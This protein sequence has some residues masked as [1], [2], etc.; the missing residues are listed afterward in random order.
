[1]VKKL[2][3]LIF[4][5]FGSV[6]ILFGCG[7]PYKDLK[8]DVSTSNIV[9][10]LNEP[11]SDESEDVPEIGDTETGSDTETDVPEDNPADTVSYPSEASFVIKVSGTGKNVSGEINIEQYAINGV[12]D[13]VS[14]EPITTDTTSRD[15]AR[16]KVTAVR[17]GSGTIVVQT[18]EGSKRHEI[19]V[20]VY[21]PIKG[22]SFIDGPK[23][24][25]YGSTVD[26]NQFLTFEPTDT[27]QKEMKFYIEDNFS[28]G[29]ISDETGIIET[30]YAKIENGILTSKIS[31][32]Y[33]VN[34]S[35]QK[36]VRIY[37]ISQFNPNV[38][39]E[40]IDLPVLNIVEES[41]ITLTAQME[42]NNLTLSKLSSGY[43]EI[44]LGHNIPDNKFVYSRDVTLQITDEY[45]TDQ[46]YVISTN[47][48]S[49]TTSNSI[50]EMD[51]SDEQARYNY[52]GPKENYPYKKFSF[53]QLK[54]GNDV[55]EVYIDRR[56]Y[57]GLFTI[58][59]QI[60]VTVKDF[61]TSLSATDEN[62]G[63]AITNG[64]VVYNAYGGNSL[65]TGVVVALSP[66]VNNAYKVRVTL[67][68]VPEINGVSGITMQLVNASEITNNSLVDSGT[69]IYLKHNFDYDQLMEIMQSETKPQLQIS[70]TFNLAPVTGMQGYDDYIITETIELNLKAG[71]TDIRIPA[72]NQEIKINAVTG[73]A[74]NQMQT[75]EQSLQNAVMTDDDTT[76][77]DGEDGGDG[78]DGEE[79]VT[80]IILATIDNQPANLQEL[81]SSIKILTVNGNSSNMDAMNNQ[82]FNIV[83]KEGPL[84]GQYNR[85]VLEPKLQADQ[86]RI[87]V[88]IKTN[89]N[90]TKTVV[91]DVFVPIVF[92]TADPDQFDVEIYNQ[93][94][95]G[96]YIYDV[97]YGSYK[98]VLRDTLSII[99]G[100]YEFPE[101]ELPLVLDTYK[102][103]TVNTLTLSVD[104]RVGLNFYNYVVLNNDLGEPKITRVNYNS[105]VTLTQNREYYT[106]EYETINGV[107]VPFIVTKKLKTNQPQIVEVRVVG[108][109]NEGNEVTL[110]KQINLNI[111]EPVTSIT[112]NPISSSLY[113]ADSLG[114][115][116]LDGSKLKFNVSVRPANA[117][118]NSNDVTYSFRNDV[119]YSLVGNTRTFEIRVEHLISLD[120]KTGEA[121]AELNQEAIR[122]L[123]EEYSIDSGVAIPYDQV[124]NSIF[125]NNVIVT[126]YATLQQYEKPAITASSTI[127][128]QNATKVEKIIPSTSS[129]GVYFD[130]RK[131]QDSNYAGETITFNV[132][133]T[134]AYNKT[135]I[136]N[137]GDE[138]VVK[139]VSGVDSNNRLIGNSITIKPNLNAGR[140]YIR[141]ASEDSY[142][143]NA[144]TGIAT[145]TSYLDISV[146]VADGTKQYPFEIKNANEFL[147]IANDFVKNSSGVYTNSYYYV[148]T[149]TFSIANL[150]FG[151]FNGVFNG[152]LS[153][154]F[155][156]D[157][158][159][160][161]YSQQN[162]ING[163]TMHVDVTPTVSSG[164][165]NV[166][167]YGIFKEL[168]TSAEIEN[169][170]LNDVNLN[171]NITKNDA[172]TDEINIGTIAGVNYGLISNSSV[173]G[174]INITTNA[175]NIN[176]GGVVGVNLSHFS[177]NATHTNGTDSQGNPAYVI[178]NFD[179]TLTGVITASTNQNSNFVSSQ[180]NSSVNI[181][182]VGNS[183]ENSNNINLGGVAGKVETYATHTINGKS[184]GVGANFNSDTVYSK[185]VSV[186][187]I[188]T[189]KTISNLTVASSIE[190]VDETGAPKLANIGGVAGYSDS[191]IFDNINVL[192]SLHGH[193]NIGGIVGYANHS[194][195]TNSSVEFANQGQVGAQTISISGY[196]N[197]G[198][199]VG[200]AKNINIYYSY[201]RAYFNNRA[202]DNTDYFG[203][204]ALLDS[205]VQEKNVGGLV[206]FIDG[207]EM[208][209][210]LST[211]GES[212]G[213][214]VTK[215]AIVYDEAVGSYVE[216]S[217]IQNY[218]VENLINSN[219]VN[220]IFNSYFNA[221]INVSFNDISK[222]IYVGG[223]V[224]STTNTKT[225][226]V[227]GDASAQKGPLTI[228]NSYVYG[229][230][231]QQEVLSQTI[232]N[233]VEII[234]SKTQ[235][236]G[237]FTTYQIGTMGVLEKLEYYNYNEDFDDLIKGGNHLVEIITETTTQTVSEEEIRGDETVKVEYQIQHITFN[238]IPI[239]QK[240]LGNQEFSISS[241]VESNVKEVVE[242]RDN[243][244]VKEITKTNTYSLNAN[245][246]NI[247]TVVQNSYIAVNNEKTSVVGNA[248]GISNATINIQTIISNETVLN[249]YSTYT[250]S[251]D[252]NENIEVDDAN[253]NR[254]D[255]NNTITM[256]FVDLTDLLTFT[257]NNFSIIK[258]VEGGSDEYVN[259]EWLLCAELNSGYPV[260]FKLQHDAGE[261][262]FKVL[263]TQ[264]TINIIDLTEAFSNLSYIKDGDNLVLLYNEL[265]SGRAYEYVNHYKIVSDGN[266]SNPQT[267]PYEVINVDLD[268]VDLYTKYGINADYDKNMVITS[269]NPTI[270]SVENGNMLVTRGVGQVTLS[271][272]SKLDTTIYDTIEVLV[273]TGLSD[274]NI[275]KT[276]NILSASNALSTINKNEIVDETN[277]NYKTGA[278]TQIIDNVSNYFVDTINEDD[279]SKKDCNGVYAKNTNIG[280]MMEVSS[281]GNGQAT[282]NG[283]A[284]EKGATYLYTSMS[285]FSFTGTYEGLVYVTLT[286][287][288]ITNQSGFGQTLT[289]TTTDGSMEIDNCILIN[290]LQ[291]TYKFNVISKA[292]SI[293]LDK[294]SVSLDPVGYVDVTLTTVTSDFVQTGEDISVNETINVQITDKASN[295]S[296]G[297]FVLDMS[298]VGTN[299]S[300]INIEILN[301]YARATDE[302]LKVELVQELRFSFDTEK[303]KDRT[304]NETYNLKDIAYTLNFYPSS[305]L[306]I[307]ANFNIQIMPRN[308]TEIKSAYYPNAETSS[309]GTFF[310]QEN[311]SDY[312]VPSRAGLLKLSLFPEF[313]NA[314]YVELTVNDEMKNY[315][316]FTQQLA[317]MSG[318][319]NSFVTGYRTTISQPDYLPNFRGIRL[320]NQ[321]IVINGTNIYFT[322]TYFVQLV[323]AENAPVN[324]QITFTATAYKVENNEAVVVQTKNI[325][326][327]I[328]P[329]P[330]ISITVDGQNEGL[331][332]KG[333][334]KEIEISA[335]NFEGDVEI[336]VSTLRGDTV[337]ASHRYDVETDKHFVNVGVNAQAG[338]TII[339]QA[340]ASRY[341][342]GILETQTS[343]VK[344]FIVEYLIDGVRLEGSTYVN[345]RYQYEAL[346]G[347]TNMLNVV[348]DITYNQNNSQV[349]SLR[350]ALEREA[351]GK[352][353]PD[354]AGGY[355]NNWWRMVGANQ[356]E[357]LYSNTNYGDYEFVDTTLN[358][359]SRTHYFGL[360]TI[361]VSNDN[362]FAY[363]M[364]YYYNSLGVPKIYTGADEGYDVYEIEFVFTLVI[365]DNSTYDHPN[366]I[367][368]V[369]EF[370]AL[371]GLNIDGTQNEEGAVTEG[372]YILVNDLVLDNYFPFEAN[373][374]SLDGN[375]HIITINSINT[376]KYKT[377]SSGNVGLFETISANTV[378]K[379][380]TID[381]SKMLVTTTQANAI[382][383][384][385]NTEN[386]FIDLIG[387]K[388]FNFGVL[389]GENNGSI[390]NAKVINTARTVMPDNM[391]KNMLVASTTG[392]ING[393][394]VEAKIGGIVAVN[395][396]SIS[397]SYVG[398]NATNYENEG[399]S[400]DLRSL[401]TSESQAVIT[402]PFNIVAGKSVGGFVDTN[403]GILANNYVLGVGVSNTGMIFEGTRTA[404][405]VVE[406][407]SGGEIF[408][409][410]V[411]GLETNNYRAKYEAGIYLEA[412]GNIGGFIYSNAGSISNA[413]SNI[414]ITTNSGGSG[415]F[416]YTNTETGTITNAY[417]TV[418]NANNS[419]AH[420]HFTG[421][422]D[423]SNFNN[424]GELVSCY[425]LVM[426]NETENTNE[427]ATAIMGK[428][429]VGSGEQEDGE[430]VVNDNPFRDTG[431]F[432]G[433]NFA[434]GDDENN[435][436]RLSDNTH[437]GPRLISSTMTTFSHRVLTNSRTDE[438][439]N[440]TIYDYEYDFNCPYG[441]NT[442]PL[443]V[444][445]ATEFVTFIINNSRTMTLN[446]ETLNVFGVTTESQT[447]INTPH[448][449]RLINDLDFSSITLNNFLVDGK[450]I[451]DIVFV[452]KLDG[453]GMDMTG[454][455]LVDQRQDIVHENFGLFSQVGLNDAQVKDPNFG[456]NNVVSTAIMNVNIT[457]SGFDATQ[458]V[459]VGAIAGSMYNTS[460]INVNLTGGDGVEI[461]GRNLVG[462]IAGLI[463]N[464]GSEL[465]TNV[466]TN[467]IT[468]TA[469]HRSESRVSEVTKVDSFG[470]PYNSSNSSVNLKFNSYNNDKT[471]S[472]SV[473]RN[474][475]YAGS[476]A[477]VIEANNRSDENMNIKTTKS[478][479]TSASEGD[480]KEVAVTDAIKAHRPP[481]INNLVSKIT[482]KG[483]G[484]IAAEH[485]GGLFGYVGERTHI[486]QAEYILGQN[487]DDKE[488]GVSFVQYIMGHNYGGGIAGENY[489]MLEQVEVKHADKIQTQIDANLGTNTTVTDEITNLFGDSTSIAIGG[490]AGF[491]SG[492]IIL[493]SYSK[494]DV[495]N[496]K[497]KIAG[498]LVGILK[499]TNYI[500]HTY[501]SGNVLSNNVFGG[502]V[503][504]HNAYVE[505]DSNDKTLFD[506]VFAL[507]DW[508]T[509][510]SDV[511]TENLQ[512][513]YLKTGESKYNTFELRFPEIGNQIVEISKENG[514]EDGQ[515]LP[516]KFAG[517]LV[518][519][520]N[521]SSTA[522]EL[523]KKGDGTSN[524]LK[525]TQINN[526]LESSRKT[527][528]VNN[529]QGDKVQFQSVIST[530]L[531]SA[532]ITTNQNVVDNDN[533]DYNQ[534]VS[535]ATGEDSGVPGDRLKFTNYVGQQ[536]KLDVI[537]GKTE[538]NTTLFNMFIW[539]TNSMDATDGSSVDL[540]SAGS[541]V[542]RLGDVFPRYIVG[543]YSNFNTITTVNELYNQTI[544][545]Q[546]TKNQY[547]LISA[548]TYVLNE[549]VTSA[550]NLN[551]YHNAFEGTLIG[552]Q[553]AGENPK[554]VLNIESG[555]NLTTIFSEIN[556]AT[557]MNVDFE[558]NVNAV[559]S[560]GLIN[561]AYE[562]QTYGGFFAKYVNSTV[563]SNVNFHVNF[564]TGTEIK[565]SDTYTAFGFMIGYVNN[566]TLQNISTHINSAE[567]CSNTPQFKKLTDA[568]ST[569]SISLGGVIGEVN[570]SE[571]S[572]INIV[573][574]NN[575]EAKFKTNHASVNM[576][577]TIGLANNSTI[578]NVNNINNTSVIDGETTTVLA[579]KNTN[580]NVLMVSD[581]Q[582]NKTVNYGGIIGAAYTTTINSSHF[583][584]SINYGKTALQTNLR[585]GGVVGYSENSTILQANVNDYVEYLDNGT[586]LRT[587]ASGQAF[588][589]NNP[590]SSGELQT[591]VGGVLG[592]G[593][594]T[595]VQG[596]STNKVNTSNNTNI[597]V[598]AQ[599]SEVSVGG[600]VG[601]IKNSN[602]NTDVSRVY[603]TGVIKVNINNNNQRSI[604]V[605]GI[606]G[607]A[608]GGKYES[609]YNLGEIA[610]TIGS[611]SGSNP[612]AVGGILGKSETNSAQTTL[613]LARFVNF[614]NIMVGGSRPNATGTNRRL[615]GGVAGQIIGTG[616]KF[617]GGYTLAKI[618]D[619]DGKQFGINN[620]D[621]GAINGIAYASEIN[622]TTFNK[623]YFVFDFLPYSNFTNASASANNAKVIV[624]TTGST[625]SNYGG[626]E[627]SNLNKVLHAQLKDYFNVQTNATSQ[628][629]TKVTNNGNTTVTALNLPTVFKIDGTNVDMFDALSLINSVGDES[630]RTNL[631]ADGEKLNPIYLNDTSK[632]IHT[633]DNTKHYIMVKSAV[634]GD[635][636]ELGN[637][638]N[639]V[640][641]TQ[642]A[643]G[644][645]G[646]LTSESRSD[647]P[648]ITLSGFRGGEN[649][650]ILSNFATKL[651]KYTDTVKGGLLTNN[652]GNIINVVNFAYLEG[653]NMSFIGDV[654]TFVYNNH[655]NIVQSGSIVLFATNAIDLEEHA[656]SGFVNQNHANAFIKDCYSLSSVINVLT[657]S[658]TTIMSNAS[659]IAGF[660]NINNGVIE[661]SYFGGSLSS[662][663]I[664]QNVFVANNTSGK[665]RNCF[666]DVE[667]TQ[668][669]TGATSF[670]IAL[671]TFS[672]STS[673]YYTQTEQFII[674]EKVNNQDVDIANT[675]LKTSYVPSSWTQLPTSK[676][677]AYNFAYPVINGGV[678]IPT[679]FTIYV[680]EDAD[681][682]AENPHSVNKTFVTTNEVGANKIYPVFHVGQ[683]NVL[684]KLSL[685]GMGVNIGLLSN[686]DMSKVNF[687][688]SSEQGKFDELIELNVNFYGFNHTINNLNIGDNLVNKT[689]VG[690]FAS[691][692][693]GSTLEFLKVNDATV[694]VVIQGNIGILVGRN[695][696]TIKNVDV[697]NSRIT[698][699]SASSVGGVVGL[700]TGTGSLTQAD[701]SSVN[702]TGNSNVGGAVGQLSNG[703]IQ[704]ITVQDVSVAGSNVL[705][706]VVGLA[707]KE[708][709]DYS[710][711]NPSISGVEVKGT[712][713]VTSDLEL[714]SSFNTIRK[715][716]YAWSSNYNTINNS[717]NILGEKA[718]SVSNNIGGVVGELGR[719]ATLTNPLL[720]KISV[721]GHNVVGGVAGKVDTGARIVFTT[722][723]IS[724]DNSNASNVNVN[725][726]YNAGGIAGMNKGTIEGVST[727]SIIRATVGIKQIATD[728][729]YN[730]N[731][732]GA[733]GSNQGGTI[734]NINVAFSSIY[735]SRLVG[736][737]A[738]YSRSGR[739]QNSTI[740][741]STLY[742]NSAMDMDQHTGYMPDLKI[743][744][745]SENANYKT[746]NF[747]THLGGG[748]GSGGKGVFNI[749]KHTYYNVIEYGGIESKVAGNINIPGKQNITLLFGFV[750][751]ANNGTI[752][753]T[754][755]SLSSTINGVYDEYR[756]YIIN[757]TKWNDL[758]RNSV[759]FER[760]VQKGVRTFNIPTSNNNF[761]YGN[762]TYKKYSSQFEQLVEDNYYYAIDYDY[763]S[764][765]LP[766]VTGQASKNNKDY[767]TYLDEYLDQL[768]N[769]YYYDRDY[770]E[771][772]FPYLTIYKYAYPN[773]TLVSSTVEQEQDNRLGSHEYLAKDTW[774]SA[775]PW[776]AWRNV[777]FYDTNQNNGLAT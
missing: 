614:A 718:G 471:N 717:G 669:T 777:E 488:E 252:N 539:D 690:L 385:E 309:S 279:K 207:D 451:S 536:F 688:V 755:G 31:D 191:T 762:T 568:S 479:E 611:D 489:G 554:I 514:Y 293:R 353:I 258:A 573:G 71:V 564:K 368:N 38:K 6:L 264:I 346:N 461:A 371:G 509:E 168:G 250:T 577:N 443:L 571:I 589:V 596:N 454:I 728:T 176:V 740:D 137:V 189:E 116:K 218:N 622:Q 288:I 308:V 326:L 439:T 424:F 531:N 100:D 99:D 674:H 226:T 343:T 255:K 81:I 222:N 365:K 513:Y 392:Y 158:A 251:G 254:T 227:S 448:Y 492:S 757:V 162:A 98:V 91:V 538:S 771:E 396:G 181:K 4:A 617:E 733:V 120:P 122:Q 192:T 198:G 272:A 259:F 652:Y 620:Q 754:V 29:S 453:N 260:L 370:M 256:G 444:N 700:N 285:E 667:A 412:K 303:Y 739:I 143:I 404:G 598:T 734:S 720:T 284:L 351:S 616:S 430:N 152:G 40:V 66:N 756:N 356:Y 49:N 557:I 682:D 354:G 636:I 247:N 672:D 462:G 637:V 113:T 217:L 668:V 506:Y 175:S 476:I 33:P 112:L 760:K 237:T 72:E 619:F 641:G 599:A 7:D 281:V 647:Y 664:S 565:Y 746:N 696:G 609:M 543:I 661:T 452:G 177:L 95:V 737:I 419:L 747:N 517:S 27:N 676:F 581:A 183:T 384:G 225:F 582:D 569:T 437:F 161:S 400:S 11:S 234:D 360:K 524:F 455:R 210:Q 671:T 585:F 62:G 722:K 401:T 57:E 699:T 101:E 32:A 712:T 434:T 53:S 484:F 314:E 567:N 711:N 537:L 394:L 14:I 486:R 493:D 132:L 769:S 425:Y 464:S 750:A 768:G 86:A 432:N 361:V 220:G 149:Q 287:F 76:T 499:G 460:L 299:S 485:A 304:G 167:Y 651:S 156:Y 416:V 320:I 673:V 335:Q 469:S 562:Q 163:L 556:T 362:V 520:L 481:P 323:L 397:N 372:H 229:N 154:N 1:M 333:M 703:T 701:I 475:S 148:L 639:G 107:R 170:I 590:N 208:S 408:N 666:Y 446:G 716:D 102:Y 545:N 559:P 626:I 530:T 374:S 297:S 194:M 328:Q 480:N 724:N 79:E 621:N 118:F 18:K 548:G 141:V 48:N 59:L 54:T 294:T 627:Y 600:I 224:G 417:S 212:E 579:N 670:N 43:Y 321:S 114:A 608:I 292:E 142:A 30:T 741:S 315:V 570:Q 261:L 12:Q 174:K 743:G 221:D 542:W 318:D 774:F 623:V 235:D 561:E 710:S 211:L 675:F 97:S 751:G 109:D 715:V 644:F 200:Y 426:E 28:S 115:L 2:S 529:G 409:C 474:Y 238:V 277:E 35:G 344:L 140:T 727:Q 505:G 133:P 203:N 350:T 534:P 347:T 692:A 24:V 388:T 630:G 340:T 729:K 166:Y 51:S 633:I 518:G 324:E 574:F 390:T 411:E 655:A 50:F 325:T 566:S 659:S 278:I 689:N 592:Y 180:E 74:V 94:E 171:F 205:N 705:G 693:N 136:V 450:R 377:A 395:N 378:I 358:D 134:D 731:I 236:V 135:L 45:T 775:F 228:K 436:W 607:W 52:S 89:N 342:N 551:A 147:N 555:K 275:Y 369:A 698:A 752:M 447:A 121:Q 216:S 500:S 244:A 407:T 541:D 695:E 239:S 69:I 742:Y 267:T 658:N 60:R 694:N 13:I 702:V 680:Q 576:G 433:F 683:L 380:I 526:I 338:D 763:S 635:T 58:T 305:N 193:S 310:P 575:V 209:A 316:N 248:E 502:A 5:V 179:Y 697:N 334:E 418:L 521:D 588:S 393:S 615:V 245:V 375:G 654:A 155:V 88:E 501:T 497:A 246:A 119:L 283:V 282:L 758:G 721:K 61:A 643:A 9:L 185:D 456:S 84:V 605:G 153:G 128:I 336:S 232:T 352:I 593:L 16:Y 642:S 735:G 428:T 26:L 496:S 553:S 610:T 649:Y 104:S 21:V 706:G 68:D 319:E 399:S 719:S 403:S 684:N 241:G 662:T 431:S 732:G 145:P 206:G 525:N 503:G 645:K 519:Y 202:I 634:D 19:N 322:G 533:T 230:I 42:T 332:A 63:N 498:G 540:A 182:F 477:G 482:V 55:V 330:S 37:A 78:E 184:G 745:N 364:S 515:L 440:Q 516:S 103:Q 85:L 578:N 339:I 331:I 80:E 300:F 215:T 157:V 242:L 146:R 381:I 253:I 214:D 773:M 629:V 527:T 624:D 366:P 707:R 549:I 289:Q 508:G 359:L 602:E 151:P 458:S 8:L 270:L 373:F 186:Y 327:T 595:K 108:Y 558:V 776:N 601:S 197:V 106:V 423:K 681:A 87:V 93:N 730:A 306:E 421:I 92:T 406:N 438:S 748:G 276:K 274:F 257:S 313:N 465:I 273:V 90:I 544:N 265:Q 70:Y 761:Y 472:L 219:S 603:N 457:I 628:F 767:L 413:Y 420:G 363:R 713:S 345:G 65:G 772:H 685:N 291:K 387:V 379:N 663:P 653:S 678:Q 271:I 124:I 348:F 631:V 41:D 249:T 665:I 709:G 240:L 165:K 298:N 290:D 402:Y 20:S 286:P 528:V 131:T 160:V 110:T 765:S 117:S 708:S 723:N 405:F 15:G 766:Y 546:G 82:F 415:G 470:N 196:A 376:E 523:G 263:P 312:I 612:Y 410:M 337:N 753:S 749:D 317:I 3:A 510:L 159:G 367:S 172:F 201:V 75:L 77:D 269:S 764:Y 382:L 487:A 442:N 199:L 483:G 449:I 17:P 64:L 341:L 725:A 96:T 691:I 638:Q 522:T 355:I 473:L 467:N 213:F 427:P 204:I 414:P 563:L 329:L 466:T 759:T 296:V 233:K 173:N 604:N 178:N 36:Y 552:V 511:L 46:Q 126:F 67:L 714:D 613:K 169:L 583:K 422:D 139:I 640:N 73:L 47:Y 44:V 686:L 349:P 23:A 660:A 445:S 311:E 280:V 625:S 243:V 386:I 10:Y 144:N 468:V 123:L 704:S 650:G 295:Q 383:K 188:L 550:A 584:G 591:F 632:T 547:Y 301:E 580:N 687:G 25:K 389:A 268:I 587:V 726:E 594:N 125:A 504:L 187:Q 130:I 586:V 56:G 127:T 679:L 223:L 491:S 83:Y 648:T 463:I 646:L 532:K 34:V 478:V 507:N 190:S 744:I 150:N 39:T 391:A 435:I 357:T 560:Q 597:T 606:V 22:V 164:D 307:S 262:L 266:I 512:Q 738:G 459:K 490:I 494:V 535:G 231:E 656:F 398:L 736:G 441:S 429:I 111:I 195:I 138:S 572:N 495:V 129:T 618:T 657:N 770:Y 105:N 677:A 302:P